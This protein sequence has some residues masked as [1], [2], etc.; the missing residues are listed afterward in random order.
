MNT[1]PLNP[2]GM[3]N[4]AVAAALAA[5]LAQWLKAYLPE[6]RFTNLLVLGLAIAVELA[7]AWLSGTHNWWVAV[8][9]GFIGAS[10]ATF[11]YETVMN[12][13]GLAGAGARVQ[14]G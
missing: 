6:W 7:A 14:D 8:W 3:L 10:V 9:A 13:L 11:G 12:L 2:D 4:P 5:L 1:F